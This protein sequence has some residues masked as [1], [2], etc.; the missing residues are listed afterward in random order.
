M[1][2]T[3]WEVI[4]STFLTT[5]STPILDPHPDQGSAGA[6]IWAPSYIVI[7]KPR[8]SRLICVFEGVIL[9]GSPLL[10]GVKFARRQNVWTDFEIGLFMIIILTVAGPTMYANINY[11]YSQNLLKV[12]S[13]K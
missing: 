10:H 5:N 9:P 13:R 12:C 8:F 4:L 3:F 6:Q 2:S 7:L 1:W 11:A